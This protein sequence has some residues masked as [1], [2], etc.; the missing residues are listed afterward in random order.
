MKK[1]SLISLVIISIIAIQCVKHKATELVVPCEAGTVYFAN[2]VQPLLNSSCAM[3]GCHDSKTKAEGY[4]FSSYNGTMQ[5]VTGGKPN[6]SKLYE[7][8]QTKNGRAKMPPQSYPALTTSQIEILNTWIL[9]GAKNN[10]CINTSPCD[11]T[12]TTY[13]TTINDLMSN[14]CTGCHNASNTSGGVNL[15]THSGVVSTVTSNKLMNTINFTSGYNQM[16]PSGLQLSTCDR[17]KIQRW[18][19]NGAK[20]N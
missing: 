9:Q 1:I 2:D 3:S 12:N 17:K 8:V 19:D 15:T 6:S 5:G 14:N 13:S 18:I 10:K 7:I 20:N 11:T 4:D 16:P